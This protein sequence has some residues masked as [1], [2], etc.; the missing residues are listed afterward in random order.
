MTR[1]VNKRNQKPGV[2]GVKKKAKRRQ[3]IE[4]TFSPKEQRRFEREA[5][6]H[7]IDL[8]EK[9]TERY[10]WAH[11]LKELQDEETQ[12]AIN[13]MVAMM[14]RIAGDPIYVYRGIQ[15]QGDE[16]L[17]KKI[18]YYNQLWI[19]MR[20]LVASAEWDITIASFRAPEK[21]CLRCGTPVR[22]K[23]K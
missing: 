2:V 12:V 16:N 3:E 4:R 8:E 6:N 17:L 20:L 1:V 10:A 19:A 23:K 14:A 22:R 21:A 18:Q 11:A 15:F 13:R 5:D 9:A 7:L